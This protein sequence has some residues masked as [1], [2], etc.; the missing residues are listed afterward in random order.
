MK[1]DEIKRKIEN[2]KL[3]IKFGEILYQKYGMPHANYIRQRMR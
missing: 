1:N 3:I 2:D